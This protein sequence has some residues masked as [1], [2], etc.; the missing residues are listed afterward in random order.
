VR[1]F[2]EDCSDDDVDYYDGDIE[3][4]VETEPI[5]MGSDAGSEE[6][7]LKNVLGA[8]REEIEEADNVDYDDYSYRSPLDWSYITDG[9]S[10]LGPQ[11]D[12][13][14]REIHELGSFQNSKL[15]SL[16]PYTKEEDDIDTRLAAL[17]RK[18]MI[19]SFRKLTLE[20]LENEDEKMEGNESKYLP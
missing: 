18:L 20:S 7:G 14:G 16:A 1:L 19:H 5:N 17:D 2:Y 4:N 6:Y 10:R 11:Y 12:K 3:D 9:T 15:G 13:H 8:A